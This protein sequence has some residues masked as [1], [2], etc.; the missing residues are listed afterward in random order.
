MMFILIIKRNFVTKMF[1]YKMKMLTTKTSSK[2]LL[3]KLGSSE[4][5]KIVN[6]ALQIIKSW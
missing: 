1:I 6:K 4:Y 5:I 3:R 2:L